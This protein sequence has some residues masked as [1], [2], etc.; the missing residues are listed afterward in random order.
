MPMLTLFIGAPTIRD[1]DTLVHEIAEARRAA[2]RHAAD[3]PTR[4]QHERRRAARLRAARALPM[5]SAP[6]SRESLAE[7]A[8]DAESRSRIDRRRSGANR[9]P[10]RFATITSRHRSLRFPSPHDR[11]AARRGSRRDWRVR[12]APAASPSSD[13]RRRRR[14]VAVIHFQAHRGHRRRVHAAAVAAPHRVRVPAAGIAAIGDLRAKRAPPSSRRSTRSKP[15]RRR[16]SCCVPMVQRERRVVPVVEIDSLGGR[17]RRRASCAVA[18]LRRRFVDRLAADLRQ[19]QPAIER[20]GRHRRAGRAV[21]PIAGQ[22]AVVAAAHAAQKPLDARPGLRRHVDAG[23]LGAGQRHHLP[24]ELARVAACRRAG[25]ASRRPTCSAPPDEK[26]T[27][28]VTAGFEPPVACHRLRF[29]QRER[30]HRVAIHLRVQRGVAEQAAVGGLRAQQEIEP[31]A[32]RVLIVAVLC[33]WP[34]PRN[35][36]SASAEMPV[37]AFRPAPPRFWPSTICSCPAPNSFASQR[38]SRDWAAASQRSAAATAASVCPLPPCCSTKPKPARRVAERIRRRRLPAPSAAL[39]PRQAVRSA[40]AVAAATQS[41]SLRCWSPP[42]SACGCCLQ[43]VLAPVASAHRLRL[44]VCNLRRL[45]GDRFG[46][47]FSGSAAASSGSTAA[48]F[49]RRR[50][51][52]R[53]CD[54]LFDLDILRRLQPLRAAARAAAARLPRRHLGRTVDEHRPPSN[55]ATIRTRIGGPCRRRCRHRRPRRFA[56]SS[57]PTPAAGAR[58]ATAPRTSAAAAIWPQRVRS[59][60]TSATLNASERT[61]SSKYA[62]GTAARRCRTARLSSDGW[63]MMR[64]STRRACRCRRCGR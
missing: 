14:R 54:R 34:A 37:S 42:D 49:R 64:S 13:A 18:S 40:T 27:A 8:A 3:A 52:D 38:P 48:Q 57:P 51:F 10:R 7:R 46:V 5:Q 50:L 17:Q 61:T 25:T 22:P 21:G 45:I 43:Q 6:K 23:P 55:R 1:R 60:T 19:Q 15:R 36:N 58:A 2:T 9:S 32:N 41:V 62:S 35:A 4:R 29:G 28:F 63:N 56:P 44:A 20:F 39:Q 53:L 47:A 31:A 26:L 59:S 11:R 24:T 16:S 33:E 30:G 12:C